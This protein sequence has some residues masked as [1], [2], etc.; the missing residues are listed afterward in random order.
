MEEKK[1]NKLTVK[2]IAVIGMMIAVIEVCKVALAWAPNIELTTFWVILFSL[3]FGKKIY[4]VIPAFIIIEGA[5][6]GIHIWWFMYLYIW[7]L[8]AIVARLFRKMESALSWAIFSCI[9][10][11][12]F[13]FLCSFP[14]VF[15]G[16]WNGGIVNGLRMA[17]AWWVA[18]IPYD[19]LH[20]V[21]NFVLMLVLYHP[22]TGVMKKATHM[23]GEF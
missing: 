14:Y 4:F 3:Y 5:M 17:F 10:G 19:I 21:G 9:F 7:P 13:G 8:L 1:S 18:G 11:L 16:A 22:I 23:L 15:I 20:G 12:F 6:Y 2:D